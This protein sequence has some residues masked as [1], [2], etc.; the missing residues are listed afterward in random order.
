ML[1]KIGGYSKMRKKLFCL[2]LIL[3]VSIISA[4]SVNA[5]NETFRSNDTFSEIYRS[6][7]KRIFF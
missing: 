2:L 1:K 5:L 6:S 3:F 7:E 4:I